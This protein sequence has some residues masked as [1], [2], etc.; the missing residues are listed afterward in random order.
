MRVVAERHAGLTGPA[1]EPTADGVALSLS[2]LRDDE[3]EQAAAGTENVHVTRLAP[4]CG[5]DG[6]AHRA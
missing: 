6:P 5:T 4:C 1:G 3:Q 2:P